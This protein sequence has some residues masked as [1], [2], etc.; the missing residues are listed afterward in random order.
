MEFSI[1]NLISVLS[2]PVAGA[3]GWFVGRSKKRNDFLS[4]LQASV[5]LL[6]EK[7]RLQMEEIVNLREEVVKF[8]DENCQLRKEVEA[9]N[10]KLE[11]VKT[12]TR[13]KS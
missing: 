5:D 6:A 1:I 4:E 8:R 11:N 12:I 2:T 3:I 7:N 9:L 13:S 10:Q